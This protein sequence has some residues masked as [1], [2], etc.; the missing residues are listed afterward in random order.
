MTRFQRERITTALNTDIRATAGQTEQLQ[1][2]DYDEAIQLLHAAGEIHA[3]NKIRKLA[4]HAKDFY[5]RHFLQLRL[6]FYVLTAMAVYTFTLGCLVKCDAATML[7]NSLFLAISVIT[8][9]GLR[10][11]QEH[12]L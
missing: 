12:K 9:V 11:I 2:H 3:C 10:H 6:A 5:T 4:L 1:Q 8:S 7:A